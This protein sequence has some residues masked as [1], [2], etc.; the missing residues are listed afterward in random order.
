MEISQKLGEITLSD[1]KKNQHHSKGQW[2]LLS[3]SQKKLGKEKYFLL[4]Y[5]YHLIR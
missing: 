1:T 3:Q 2:F 4:P 5:K